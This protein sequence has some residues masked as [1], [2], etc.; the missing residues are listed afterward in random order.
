M[1]ADHGEGDEPILD[2]RKPRAVRGPNL[3]DGAGALDHRPHIGNLLDTES[4]EGARRKHNGAQRREHGNY[5]S[6]DDDLADCPGPTG[7]APPPYQC[8]RLVSEYG[9][10]PI[11]AGASPPTTATEPTKL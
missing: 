11:F 3:V 1:A 8:S 6:E 9:R 5:S 4:L 10:V 2:H 7:R